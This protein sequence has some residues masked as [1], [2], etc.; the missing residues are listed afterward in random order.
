MKLLTDWG[1]SSTSWKGQRGEYWVLLQGV[2][3]LGF[4]VLPLYQPSW[5]EVQPPL[6]YCIWAIATLLGAV[7]AVFVLKGLLDLGSNL[8]PLPYP[9][10]D[11]QLVQ[12]GIYGIVRHPLYSGLILA[13][14]AYALRQLSLS[15]LVGALVWLI[16]FDLKAR[17]E[18]A[19]LTEKF[20]DYPTYRQHV[21]K[22]LPWLY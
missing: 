2:L 6:Q 15:H 20:A 5:L 10:L 17:R 9:K 12:S 21:K 18:E 7:G 4:V 11:S 16:F 13:A 1:F 14:T 8:T 22:L 19:W 3:I